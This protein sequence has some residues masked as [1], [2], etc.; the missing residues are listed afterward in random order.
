M[1]K[2]SGNIV[3][4]IVWIIFILGGAL[5]SFYLDKLFFY[6]LQ[7]NL[8]FHIVMFPLGA[9]LLYLVMRISKNTGRT[10]ANYGRNGN[11]PRMQTNAFVTQGAYKYMKHPMHLGLLL[12]PFSV[13]LII[14]SLS[15][16]LIIAPVEAVFML[17]MIKVI[18]EPGVI[19]KFGNDYIDFY[20]DKSWFCFRKECLSA[21]F[22][23]VNKN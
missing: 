9:L 21:L 8:A 5:A 13:A 3:R 10:L 22:K 23:D 6:L 14:G 4:I 2:N 7:K 18:E 11:L 17:I 20:K 19:E 12:F 16:V 15:F 1:H